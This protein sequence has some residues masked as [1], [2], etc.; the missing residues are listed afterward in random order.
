VLDDLAASVADVAVSLRDDA[1]PTHVLAALSDL[2]QPILPHDRL[3]VDHLDENRRTFRVFAEHV[4]RGPVLHED[5]YTT[6]AGRDAR[7]TVAE[8]AIRPVFDGASMVV[9]DFGTDPR[10]ADP[11]VFERRLRAD[12]VRAGLVVPLRCG[13]RV[14]GALVATSLAADVYG[15]AHL[16]LARRVADHI[17]AVVDNAVL[18]QRERRR[19]ERLA[20]LDSPTRGRATSASCRTRSSAR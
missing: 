8:W 14:I 12:G 15:E 6:D 18:R 16:A 13:G 3:V 9:G 20:A 17:A 19:R 11:N 1:P 5:H 2:L 7:Y 4:V 10:F